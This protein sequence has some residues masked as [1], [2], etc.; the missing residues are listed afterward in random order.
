MLYAQGYVNE[1]DYPT[2]RLPTKL[3]RSAK[4]KFKIAAPENGL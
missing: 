4:E 2:V 3:P 1:P